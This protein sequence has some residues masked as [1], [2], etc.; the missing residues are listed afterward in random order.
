MQEN[1]DG[2]R[3]RASAHAHIEELTHNIPPRT[4]CLF[5]ERYYHCV[6]IRTRAAPLLYAK[7]KIKKETEHNLH[8]LTQFRGKRKDKEN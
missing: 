1:N 3:T 6:A 4:S 2:V 5:N 8:N 7:E